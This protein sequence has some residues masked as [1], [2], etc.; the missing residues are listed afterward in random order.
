MRPP[1]A[2]TDP[3]R[4]GPD[5]RGRRAETDPPDSTVIVASPHRS[6][7]FGRPTG[8]GRA[9]V[10][11]G[12]F[13]RLYLQARVSTEPVARSHPTHGRLEGVPNKRLGRSPGSRTRRPVG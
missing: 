11:M 10:R 12:E 8:V 5:R 4:S 3:A 9:L 6:V 13:S 2:T 1:P 7:G